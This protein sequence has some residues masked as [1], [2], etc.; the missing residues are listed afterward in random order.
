MALCTYEKISPINPALLKD[1]G[2]KADEKKS[3]RFFNEDFR[4]LS[5]A[6]D[7]FARSKK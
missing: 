4:H 5:M 1:A 3:F 7:F 2:K 6:V